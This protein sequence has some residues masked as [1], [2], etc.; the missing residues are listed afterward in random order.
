MVNNKD[1][2]KPLLVFPHDNIFYYVQILQRKKD[3][4]GARLGRSNNNSRVIKSYYINS[5]E[6]LE[7][8]WEEMVKLAELFDARVSINLNPRSFEKAAFDLLIKVSNQMKNRDFYNVRKSYESVCGDYHAETDK[9]W[10][11]DVDKEDISN[12]DEI[13][14]VVKE[15][16]ADLSEHEVAKNYKVLGVL[17]SKSGAHI[18]T[19]PFNMQLWSSLRFSHLEIHKNNPTNLYIP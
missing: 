3:R 18:I 12:L 16:H 13:L 9:R 19:N 15:L 4:V 2:I 1:L 7:V 5:L 10:L 17:P 14:D 8:Q 6:K 11:I